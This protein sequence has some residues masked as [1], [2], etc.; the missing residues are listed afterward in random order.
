LNV[1]NDDL[2]NRQSA[3]HLGDHD[4]AVPFVMMTV[5]VGEGWNGYAKGQQGCTAELETARHVSSC[6]RRT[7]IMGQLSPMMNR[8]CRIM[9]AGATVLPVNQVH[10]CSGAPVLGLST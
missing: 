10:R 2:S 1:A 9:Q 8:S 7:S 3:L 6:H 5:F 4:G